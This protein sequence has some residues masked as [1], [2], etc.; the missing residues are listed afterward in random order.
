MQAN[1]TPTLLT[2]LEGQLRQWKL[3]YYAQMPGVT[4]DD[5]AAAARRL[6]E[7]RAAYERATGR[8]VR[9]K[10]TAQAIANLLR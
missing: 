5:M 9:T 2:V 7:A 6:L 3:A 1:P 10:V 4:Y 8:P